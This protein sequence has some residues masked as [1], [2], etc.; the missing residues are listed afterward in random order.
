MIETRINAAAI[1]PSTIA[2]IAMDQKLTLLSVLGVLLSFICRISSH[3]C[4][5]IIIEA[6]NA[7]L[8]ALS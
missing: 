7:K 6:D 8:D 1:Y 3:V 4:I 5:P 2:I